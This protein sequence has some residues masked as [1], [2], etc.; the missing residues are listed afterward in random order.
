LRP[1]W[2]AGLLLA[3]LAFALAASRRGEHRRHG[4]AML[5]VLGLLAA[6]L[7]FHL[8]GGAFRG[9]AAFQ[10]LRSFHRWA[11]LAGLM[12]AGL[13]LPLGLAALA[14]REGRGAEPRW[15]RRHKALGRPAWTLL[16]LAALLGLGLGF[17][18][19]AG[20]GPT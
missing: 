12:L 7:P 3:L 14:Y 6:F 19:M 15:T 9:L 13:A 18:R 8:G 10:G 16:A 17:L 1:A 11:A 4:G 20:A 2:A 5:L